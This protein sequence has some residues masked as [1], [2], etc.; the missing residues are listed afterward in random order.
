[1]GSRTAAN[2]IFRKTDAPGP[3]AYKPS[4]MF[5]SPKYTMK[6]K[7]NCGTALVANTDGTHEKVPSSPD[8]KVPGPG[9][10][11]LNHD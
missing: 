4:S 11:S 5:T 2:S 8:S 10:Y 1:M 6:G 9:T 7:Y 3:G